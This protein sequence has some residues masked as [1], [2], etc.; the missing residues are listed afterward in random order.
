MGERTGK[1][2]VQELTDLGKD[3]LLDKA[4]ATHGSRVQKG[5]HSYFPWAGR[6][7]AT[8]RKAGPITCSGFLAK[9]TPS[10]L[11]F[12]IPPSIPQ[13]DAIW[14]LLWL[15]WV[16]CPG[17]VP[18]QPLT[19]RAAHV[20]GSPWL[21]VSTALQQLS[22]WCVTTTIV[23]KSPKHEIVQ[24]FMKKINSITT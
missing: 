16:C 11:I 13:H 23:L 18:F 21:C 2:K 10:L 24:V 7:S 22:G 20:A 4:K 3:S 6:C 15:V 8:S 19:S 14:T 9:Q 12:P 5:I 1:V 17:S